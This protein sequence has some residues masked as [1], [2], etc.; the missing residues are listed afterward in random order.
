MVQMKHA[1]RAV[2]IV[3]AP[4]FI[5]HMVQMKLILIFGFLKNNQALYP[6][7]FR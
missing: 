6:T 5:S 3:D 1:I 2:A 7:W 4:I